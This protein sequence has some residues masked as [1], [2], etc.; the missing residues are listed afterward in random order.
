M[1]LPR[2]GFGTSPFR[3]GVPIDVEEPVRTAL[4]T[5]YRLFDTAEAY[6]NESKV[7]RAFHGAGSPPRNELYIMGKVWPTNFKPE[8]LRPA[9]EASLRRLGID[10][11]D[12]YVLHA[13]D[14][15]KHIAPLDDTDKIGWDEFFRRGTSTPAPEVPLAETWDAM[16]ALVDAGLA[17]SIGV[18]NFTPE[19][20]GDLGP[21]ANQ[22]RC[23]PHEQSVMK[24][25][26]TNPEE[27]L[28]QAI[29]SEVETRL[30]YQKLAE[31][32]GS[33]EVKNR[34][35]QLADNELV[36]RAKL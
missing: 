12:L 10:A 9:C 18:S 15:Q 27:V 28:R 24:P 19:Q 26:E 13:H 20:I 35:L 14:A 4:A 31:R 8:H 36:H 1:N 34:L 23:W 21:A 7:G 3:G 2:I 17:G 29:D 30:Y 32:A 5:G 22:I 25:L 16:R 6:G 11:F 33:P